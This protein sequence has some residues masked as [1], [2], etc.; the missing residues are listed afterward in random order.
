MGIAWNIWI[1]GIVAAMLIGCVWL[2]MW[3]GKV[4]EDEGDSHGHVWDEDITELNNPLPRWWLWM[5]Y[6][7]IIFACIYLFLYPG[8]GDYKG[9]LD[10]SQQTMYAEEVAEFEEKLAPLFSQYRAQT[11]EQ[12]STNVDATNIGEKLYANYCAACHGADAKG[13]KGFPNLTDTAW[14]YGGSGDEIKTSILNG[15]NGV[16]QP[17][18]AALSEDEIERVAG[19]VRHLS[20]MTKAT[21]YNASGK[22]KF[23]MLCTAC[24]GVD[25]T[26]NK[27]LGAPNLTDKA[28]LYGGDFTTVVETIAAGRKGNMPAHKDILGDDKAHVVAAYIYSLSN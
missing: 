24:H 21:D 4:G 25:G 6:L 26:G 2:L 18:S 1:I 12:L 15:R 27:M 13:A 23:E 17:F 14:L 19:Y 9:K 11:V 16:M 3:T 20:G 22:A 8:L 7:S 5:F 10:W 28:W